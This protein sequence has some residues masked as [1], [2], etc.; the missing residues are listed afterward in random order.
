MQQFFFKCVNATK[1]KKL[2]VNAT[3]RNQC[4]KNVSAT[5]KK[6]K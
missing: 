3:K 5:K 1:K 2:I 6:K 4:K